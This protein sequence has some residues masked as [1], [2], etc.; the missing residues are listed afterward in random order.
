MKQLT[1][2]Q[3]ALAFIVP[4]IVLGLIGGMMGLL[5][6]QPATPKA[7]ADKTSTA[8]NTT[9]S[10]A[11]VNGIAKKSVAENDF[12]YVVGPKDAKVTVVEFLDLECPYCKAAA[13]TVKA[14]LARYEGKPV[15]FMFR[16]F[17][18]TTLHPHALAGAVAATCAKEQGKFMELYETYY[19]QD[20]LDDSSATKIAQSI[21]LDM[22]KFTACVDSNRYQST[23]A[24]DLA[25][26]LDLGIDG[27]PTFFINGH[28]LA[29]ALPIE[30]FTAAIDALLPR[31]APP[32]LNN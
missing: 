25:D 29:G 11:Y 20:A 10:S 13:P 1:P 5:A 8:A 18:L 7:T 12:A 15:K 2:Q 6:T 17:P 30:S 16:N 21:G 31:T 26:G 24:I 19:T 27:T 4:L 22:P 3:S 14:L 23:I 32:R 9:A 28:K